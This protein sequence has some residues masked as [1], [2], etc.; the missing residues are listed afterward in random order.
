MHSRGYLT[1]ELSEDES[2]KFSPKLLKYIPGLER[3][4]EDGELLLEEEADFKLEWPLWNLIKEIIAEFDRTYGTDYGP[5]QVSMLQKAALI[6]ELQTY[7]LYRIIRVAYHYDISLLLHVLIQ[8]IIARSLPLD[9]AQIVLKNPRLGRRPEK[10]MADVLNNTPNDVINQ[11]YSILREIL[12]TAF[13]YYIEVYDLLQIIESHY[14]PETTSV[15]AAGAKHTAILTQKGLL[16]KGD[17]L[18]GALGLG[19][20]GMPDTPSDRWYS[21][22]DLSNIISVWAGT[23]HTLI[24]T[25]DRGLLACGS[26]EFG[27]AGV[28][29]RRL[30]KRLFAPTKVNLPQTLSVACGTY[31]TLVLTVDGMFGFGRNTSGQLGVGPDETRVLVPTRVDTDERMV[32]VA[33]GDNFSL[34]LGESGVVYHAGL[35]LSGIP[36]TTKR[37]T[38]VLLPEGAGKIA[39]IHTGTKHA[40]FI[41]TTME[42]FLWGSNEH[43]QLGLGD[44]SGWRTSVVK[45]PT[46]RGIVNA[47]A[48]TSWSMFIDE[49]GGL[50]AAGDNTYNQLGLIGGRKAST[51]VPVKVEDAQNVISVACGLTFTKILTCGGLF[52]TAKGMPLLKEDI[53]K[54]SE[55]PICKRQ[56]LAAFHCHLCGHDEFKEL[57]WNTRNKRII[58]SLACKKK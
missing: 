42:V 29:N 54:V 51:S 6:D 37:F 56:R 38:Q 48:G 7:D 4:Y 15:L 26:N 31:H 36:V 41:N 10:G 32:A 25:S 35:A 19:E 22:P 45:H 1:L 30:G 24:L 50:Y 53:V 3:E 13:T 49:Q 23:D 8:K 55:R 40:I 46:L 47:A 14:L 18:Y 20:I 5:N 12:M 39:S 44:T 2:I 43:A 11:S 28:E 52:T 16:V 17:N 9:V 58:C 34:L 57:S 21:V 27:Q 33:C